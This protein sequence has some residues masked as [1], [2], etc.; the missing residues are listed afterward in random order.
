MHRSPACRFAAVLQRCTLLWL[1]V[2]CAGLTA[3]AAAAAS[4]TVQCLFEDNRIYV[5]VQVHGSSPRWFILD[6]G[7]APTVV[8]AQLAR[9]LKLETHGDEVVSGVGSGQSHQQHTRDLSLAIGSTPLH[10]GD[11]AVADLAGLLGPSS[12]RAPAGVIGS[13]FFLE[14]VVEFDFD[15]ARMTV[16]AP[17]TDLST[18][19]DASVPL[20]FNSA[21]PMADMRLQLASGKTLRPRVVVDL[22]AKSTLLLPEPF[23]ARTHLREALP[24][25]VVSG[26]GAGMGGDTRYAFARAQQLAFHAAPALALSQPL[27]GLSVDGTLRSRWHDGLLGAQFLSRFRIAFDYRRSRLLLTQLSTRPPE[28]DRSGMYL[29][30]SGADLRRVLVREVHAESP[31][32]R[33]GLQPGDEIESIDDAAVSTLGLPA[34]RAT[35][36]SD[37]AASVTLGIA[38]NGRRWNV[39]LALEN[40]L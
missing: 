40:V 21:I 6:T 30:A 23:I 17:D 8:D 38:R 19:Y 3:R 20:H 24:H 18:R 32:A 14:H 22:G 11:A 10:I 13:Q 9:E 4:D 36:R 16:H 35:L 12:G 26:F 39:D 7:A 15:A 34:V 33:A 31:A 2:F 25:I 29:M 5:P 37:A 28:F 1:C 27:L